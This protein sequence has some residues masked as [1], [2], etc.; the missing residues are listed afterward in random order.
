MPSLKRLLC[1]LLF[2]LPGPAVSAGAGQPI[3]V[4]A[5]FSQ[6]GIAA[7]HNAPLIPMVELAA[8]EVN[9]AGGFLGR[10]VELVLLDNQSTPIGS[11]KAAEEAV[12][13]GALAVI[14]AHWSSH[15]LAMAPILQKAGIPMISPGSTNPEVTRVGDF[16]FRA[17]FV[18]SFQGQAMA[19]FAV[20]ELGAKKAVVLKNIDEAYSLM[21]SEYFTRSFR[22]F[23]GRILLDEGYRGKAVDFSDPLRK[24]A[25]LRPDVVYVPGYTRDS[26]LLIKQARA[27]GIEAT[28]L[29]G[30][31]W[32]EIQEYAGDAINGSYHSAPWHPDVP[33]PESKHLQE[34]YREKLGTGITNVSAPLAYDAFMLLADAVRRAGTLERSKVR[35]ALAATRDFRGAT[36]SITMNENRDPQGKAVVILRWER[37]TAKYVRAMRP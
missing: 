18:D 33:F 29:G 17:C 7:A 10:R 34:R 19:R 14:G 3:R 32:D 2:A 1:T 37:G 21:L 24:L 5:I 12:R 4:A 35:Q 22:G 16:V 36:G 28:F 11:A 20:S 13:L 6:T 26:G 27:M 15:S 30:D 9:E 23:G 8:D 31:A 25:N